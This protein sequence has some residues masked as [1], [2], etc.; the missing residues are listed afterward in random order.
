[1]PSTSSTSTYKKHLL[2]TWRSVE[3]GS[4]QTVTS[5][6]FHPRL[7]ILPDAQ[8]RFW[9]EVAATPREFVLYGGT[10]IALRLGHRYSEDFD[11]FSNQHFSPRELLRRLPYLKDTEVLQE[12]GN[13]LTCMADRG[14]PVRVSF[15]GGLDLNRVADPEVTTNS[16]VRVASL[17]DLAATKVVTVL[18]RA[19]LKD[20][21]DVDA[22]LSA[23]VE[24]RV[25]LAAA[26]AVYGAQYNPFLS[27]KA[28]T[29]FE[30]GDVKK[31][32][33]DCRRRLVEAACRVDVQNLPDVQA[34]PGLV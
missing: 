27:L 28:L 3:V 34:R 32:S 24:L 21:Q 23:G 2:D 33:S 26:K 14:G 11:F 16:N 13:T 17:L 22:L 25:A 18:Q 6:M 9:E 30:E 5:G 19:S 1:M 12:K 4:E 31:L 7:D 15:F 20:Y 8:R 10:A 29:F